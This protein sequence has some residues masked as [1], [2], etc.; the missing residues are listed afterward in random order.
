M[1][2]E[3]VNQIVLL[4][5]HCFAFAFHLQISKQFM[6]LAKHPETNILGDLPKLK[7]RKERSC[8][9]SQLCFQP[10]GP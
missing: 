1:S 5:L 3:P 8:A 2:L 9:D 10:T 7:L 6:Q 4:F